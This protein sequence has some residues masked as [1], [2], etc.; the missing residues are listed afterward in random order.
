MVPYYAPDDAI[1]DGTYT[2]KVYARDARNR[3][4]AEAAQGEFRKVSDIVPVINVEFS[5][6]N[7]IFRWEDVDAAAY[8]KI[9]IAD[10]PQFS[11]NY[12]YAFTHNTTFTPRTVP[13]AV[14]DGEFFWR[15]YMYDN[16]NNPGP[17]I[18]LEFD[19]FPYKVY[20]PLVIR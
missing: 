14:E 2:W 18:D 11:S 1:K 9:E 4:S 20:L 12:T 10:D 15:V 7:L 6:N 8:Y 3:N 19:L 16:K 13:R 17:N 5:G